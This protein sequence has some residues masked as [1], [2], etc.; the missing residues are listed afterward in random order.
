MML[1]LP[2]AFK[3]IS[4]APE[5]RRDIKPEILFFPEE[6]SKET[7]TALTEIRLRNRRP[8]RMSISIAMIIMPS[9]GITRETRRAREEWKNNFG[10]GREASS[11]RAFQEKYF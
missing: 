3:N 1:P 9:R 8:K 4:P 11:D 5:I 2:S 6:E 7:P 10:S